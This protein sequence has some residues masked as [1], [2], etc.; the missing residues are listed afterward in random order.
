MDSISDG[1]F[2]ADSSAPH[3]YGYI[4]NTLRTSDFSVGVIFLSCQ[5]VKTLSLDHD[6]QLGSR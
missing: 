2:A 4:Q 1:V 6:E 3:Q 5:D